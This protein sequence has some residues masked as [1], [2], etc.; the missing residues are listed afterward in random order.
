MPDQ[1]SLL[2]ANPFA[3]IPDGPDDPILGVAVAFQSDVSPHKI[4]LGIGAYRTE[5]GLPYVLNAVRSVLSFGS[6]LF[7]ILFMHDYRQRSS[8]IKRIKIKNTL[9]SPAFRNSLMPL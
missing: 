9:H 2:P 5:A 7:S 3:Q 4:N 6:S 8:T 1:L